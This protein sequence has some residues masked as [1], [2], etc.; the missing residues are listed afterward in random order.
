MGALAVPGLSNSA[1]QLTGIGPNSQ[2][3]QAL[4]TPNG[5][6][7]ELQAQNSVFGDPAAMG[8]IQQASG[9]GNV[10]DAINQAGG[11]GLQA[12]QQQGL[13]NA[14]ATG[15]TT[16]SQ[17]AT[18][19]VQSN[20]LLSQGLNQIQGQLQTGQGEQAQQTGLLNNMQSQGFNLTPGDQSLYGQE[21]GQIANQYA[22]QGNQAANSLASRGL[23]SS[24]AAGAQFSGI[25]GNQNQQLAQAQQQ[26]AQQRFTNTQNQI[27]QQ[28]NFI[29]SL[30]S[31]N[32]QAANNY[33][34]QAANDVN[35]QYGRQLAGAQ[36]QTGSLEAGATANNAANTSTLQ[37]QTFNAQNAPAT[38]GNIVTG[39]LGGSGSAATGAFGKSAGQSAGAGLFGS[40]GGA[41]AAAA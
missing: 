3:P 1:Q 20:P 38:L 36:Q 10:Q 40:G 39:A 19:Q 16:G 37:G 31:Q 13:D 24:G 4:N 15:A 8:L 28:Q 33:S 26:I 11:L 27:A 14:L 34:G 41:A 12:N 17:Y 29:G 35:Q 7:N 21:A 25:A 22:Q 5:S 18:Q 9:T 23:S 32:N 30:N 6:N 2:G